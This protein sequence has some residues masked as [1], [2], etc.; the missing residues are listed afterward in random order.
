MAQKLSKCTHLAKRWVWQKQGNILQVST[1][2][3]V[4]QAKLLVRAID[5]VKY[6][7][8]SVILSYSKFRSK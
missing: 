7:H 4:L 1:F 8:P 2:P 5:W 3:L 6:L